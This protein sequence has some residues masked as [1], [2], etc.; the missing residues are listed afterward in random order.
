M[1]VSHAIGIRPELDELRRVWEQAFGWSTRG[2]VVVDATTGVIHSVNPAF[3]AMHGGVV[4]DFV[5]QTGTFVLAP[6]AQAELPELIKRLGH[7]GQLWITHDHARLDG[8]VFPAETEVITT[9][10]RDGRPLYRMSWCED[11]TQQRAAEAAH[12]KT[13]AM[14]EAAFAYAPNG[15]AMIGLDGRFLRVNEALCAM[16][17]RR[18]AELVGHPTIEVCHPD[19]LDATE[20]AYEAMSVASE[21]VSIEQRYVRPDGAVVWAFCRG[22][23]VCDD[24]D[25]PSYIITH[26]VDFTA[27]KLAERREADAE[28][29]FERAFADAPIGMA[30][31]DLDGA[32]LKV[33]RS[34]QEITGYTEPDLLA[35]SLQ[36]ITHPEDLEADREQVAALLDGQTERYAVEQV[37][38]AARGRLI[39]TKVARSLVRDSDGQP[40]HFIV[41]VEDISARKRMEASLQRLADHD[42]L[43]DLW[44][45]RRFEEELRRQ[46]ARCRRYGEK[47]ALLLLDIDGFKAVDDTFGHKAGDDLLKLVAGALQRRLRGTDAVARLGGDEFAVL[48]ANVSPDQAAELAE[49]LHALVAAATIDLGG[50]HLSVTASVGVVFL[51]ERIAGEQDAMIQADVAMYD[52]KVAR[53]GRAA[54][55]PP[56][57]SRLT[58]IPT[59]ARTPRTPSGAAFAYCIATTPRP[60]GGSCPRC[61]SSSL[62][63]RSSLRRT[64]ARACSRPS[65]ATTPT[66]SSSMPRSTAWTIRC[67]PDCARLRRT[68]DSSCCRAWSRKDHCSRR[69]PTPTC[70]SRRRSTTSPRSSDG[71]L[72][73]SCPACS[74]SGRP[75]PAG[76]AG[77]DRDRPRSTRPAPRDAGPDRRWSSPA[78]CCPQG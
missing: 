28:L 21:P 75:G 54:R 46:V 30:L 42:P 11:L 41:H 66:S 68:P 8:S 33:N 5:G 78:R 61:W 38:F 43:T 27:R 76:R 53:A 22:I 65:P 44:N 32:F 57:S 24:D 20:R 67:S 40:V 72:R 35:L 69:S 51:D 18:E 37:Y 6:G 58:I 2:I 1:H 64:T 74:W 17:G 63:S 23:V 73:A 16:L 62:T 60:T 19:D 29:R 10:D 34:L 9:V 31:V 4:A 50:R 52:V 70:A 13:G 3:A 59:S 45:R 77:A 49:Q 14:F 26:F 12:R 47:A 56:G 71:P 36:E 15:V 55:A 7:E 39:W 25:E 48:L